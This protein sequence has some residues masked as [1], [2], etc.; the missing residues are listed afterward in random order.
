[1]R[2]ARIGRVPGTLCATDAFVLAFITWGV[3]AGSDGLG[4]Q[5]RSTVVVFT[6]AWMTAALTRLTEFR[7]GRRPALKLMRSDI[8][9]TA[10]LLAGTAPWLLLG[11]LRSAYPTSAI[12][13]PFEVP[14]P[15]QALGAAFAIAAVV[16]P[17]RSTRTPSPCPDEAE[18]R[19]SIALLIRS[20]AILLLSGSPVFTAF[21][22]L[23]LTIAVWRAPGRFRFGFRTTAAATLAS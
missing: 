19:F 14:L 12:W 5:E 2:W 6:I 23:W 7:S 11:F 16:E 22:A 17:F 10:I 8:R 3:T 13:I 4:I 18:C 21:C 1:M 15:L 9:T 20:A